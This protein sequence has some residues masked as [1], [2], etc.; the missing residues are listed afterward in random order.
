MR[1]LIHETLTG[2]PVTELEIKSGSWSM[3]I[4]RPDDVS[5]Q[6][7]GYT[8]Q[9]LWPLM[10]PRKYMLTLLEDDGRVRGSGLLGIPEGVDNQDGLH[11]VSLS[12]K[13]IESYFEKRHVL[14]YPF[15]PLVDAAGY[16][17]TSRDTFI[18]KVEYGT[19]IKRLYQQ[20]L[21]HPGAELPVR[22]EADRV[23]TR[24]K[25]W[26]AVD[27]KPVQEAVED[28]SNI[29][30]GVEWDWV[31]AVDEAD[32]L[33]LTLITATDVE[34]EITSDFWHT[35]QQGGYSP[36]IRGL[37]VK[38]SPEYMASTAIFSGGKDD[39]RTMF[40]QATSLD[41]ILAGIPQIEVWDSSHSSVSQQP[42]LDGWAAKR[43]AEGQAPVQ[44]WSFEVRADRAVGLRHGDWCSVE[45][46]DHWLIPAGS[47]SRRVVEV[48]GSAD[49]DW[50]GLTVAGE[51]SW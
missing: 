2:E 26:A 10:V 13:G 1:A 21:T 44:Y 18:D 20:A 16:P 15:W 43:I 24:E 4:C 17:L 42:T 34:Q 22:W 40:A 3:G 19:M 14:P 27:G 32:R 5:I 35:W 41:L 33:S 36:D 37:S 12:G 31:P 49:S 50:L 9:N 29:L 25:G 28:I 38:V 7:P 46:S 39:D 30:N 51:L 11:H 47:Y 48:S 6:T 45:V 8:G 23:G